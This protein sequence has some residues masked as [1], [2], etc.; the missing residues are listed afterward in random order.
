VGDMLYPHDISCDMDVKIYFFKCFNYH[1]LII[2]NGGVPYDIFKYV[3]NVL[4]IIVTSIT[5][6]CSPPTPPIPSSSQ[7][8]PFLLLH[9]GLCVGSGDQMSL[10]RVASKSMSKD[11]FSKVEQLNSGHTIEDVSPF[12]RNHLLPQD[13]Q[14]DMGLVNMSWRLFRT[15]ARARAHTHTHTHNVLVFLKVYNH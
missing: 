1:T 15:R 13:P 2:Y 8:A 9:F 12:L 4:L 7:L 10:I 5:L 11:V 14:G 3:Y 6:S